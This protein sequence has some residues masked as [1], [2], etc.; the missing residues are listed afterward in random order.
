MT[1]TGKY[2]FYDEEAEE[3]RR[4]KKTFTHYNYRSDKRN[5]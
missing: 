1:I 3:E 5:G 4:L 2:I